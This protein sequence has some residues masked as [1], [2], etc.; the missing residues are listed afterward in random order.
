[1]QSMSGQRIHYNR[2]T[3]YSQNYGDNLF[4]AQQNL[5]EKLTNIVKIEN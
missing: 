3:N 4:K 1:M 2:D 5:L